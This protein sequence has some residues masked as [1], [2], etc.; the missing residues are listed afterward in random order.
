MVTKHRSPA[1]YL[2]VLLALTIAL[3]SMPA[4]ASAAVLPPP[5]TILVDKT[6]TPFD[7]YQITDPFDIATIQS[8]HRKT[9]VT[10]T[11]D[12]LP[13]AAEVDLVMVFDV[14]FS[15]NNDA[16]NAMKAAAK[17][18][19]ASI[20]GANSGSRVA[21]ARYASRAYAYDFNASGWDGIS[22][23]NTDHGY[24]TG[25]LTAINTAI[26]SLTIATGDSGGT[27]SEGG[28]LTADWIMEN[29]GR[30]D[31]DFDPSGTRAIV[32]MSDG[33][34]TYRYDSDMDPQSGSS[35]AQSSYREL[36]EGMEAGAAAGTNG[37]EIN[38]IFTIGLVSGL[39]DYSK[40]V[41][42]LF[43]N[44]QMRVDSSWDW[45]DSLATHTT[46]DP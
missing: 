44:N 11:V 5:G 31:A 28:F 9:L 16:L 39:D 17:S 32:F 33:V 6:A 45:G 37:S 35:G 3:L 22:S 20:I 24:F 43:L 1:K 8:G 19:A 14:S 34:P 23:L 15:M 38:Q 46:A 27:N 18:M 25:D 36:N 40:G 30:A 2:S 13:I 12:A 7:T 29:Q 4:M 10:L 42:R 41:A 26:D 21:I